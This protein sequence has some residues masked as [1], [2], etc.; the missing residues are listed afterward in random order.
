MTVKKHVKVSYVPVDGDAG[1]GFA[2]MKSRYG[3][4][5]RYVTCDGKPCII[6]AGEFHFSRYDERYWDTEVAKMKSQGLNCISTYVFWNHHEKSCGKFDFSGNRNVS[7]F[8]KTCKRHGLKVILRIGPWCHGEV[9][10]GGFPDYLAFVPGKRR[11][12]PVYLHFVKRFWKALYAEVKDYLDGETVVGIQLENE[13]GGG[14]GHIVK[15][16][17]IAESIGFRTPFF[18]MTA[19]PTNTPDDRFLPTFGGYPEAPW[20][21]NKSPLRPEGR[22]AITEGRSETEIGEDLLGKSRCKADFSKYPYATC[23][24]GTG[25]QVTQ[26]RRPVI[27]DK[28]GYGVAFAKL[29]SGAVWL[30]YYMYHGGRNPSEKPMQESRRTLYPN[31][32]PIVDYDFQAPLS[33]DGKVRKHADRLRLMHYFLSANESRFART[34]AFF[35]K[36]VTMPYF[37]YRADETGGYVFVSNYERGAELKDE[38]VDIVIEA[39]NRSVSVKELEVAAGDMYFIPIMQQYGGVGFDYITAQPVVETLENGCAHAYFVKYGKTVRMCVDGKETETAEEEATFNGGK[40]VLHFL[41]PEKAEKLYCFAGKVIF[42]DFPLYEKDGRIYAEESCDAGV[43]GLK[44]EKT[45]AVVLPY[46]DY[47]F[48]AGARGYYRLTADNSLLD[49]GDA[50]ITLDFNGLNLQMFLDGK[51]VDDYFNT[52]GKFV[53]RLKRIADA[54]KQKTELIVRTCAATSAGRG[55]T[56]NEIG[57]VP[58]QN[59]LKI[60]GCVK[61]KTSV[62]KTDA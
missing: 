45:D 5:H 62:L 56:Y 31:D 34:Q 58:G 16:R 46:D 39:E 49:D 18:S 36:D 61:I 17:E 48:S 27:S 43:D 37:S 35:C 22:F 8:I 52:D 15:L 26:H 7:E 33:K 24:I 10:R 29:A 23:E 42:S 19:W 53:F 20:T 55:R 9:V 30:G 6:I 25:N 4:T 40:T 51:I 38:Q 2:G 59:D 13:Y 54:S 50:E 41:D 60:S 32:Y 12:T 3:A 1:F 28:D 57:I 47:M 21:Q 44:L 14:I 11:S